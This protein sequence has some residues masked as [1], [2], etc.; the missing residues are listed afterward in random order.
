MPKKDPGPPQGEGKRTMHKDVPNQQSRGI[1]NVTA[2]L[3][4]SSTSSFVYVLSTLA[5]II[6]AWYA[7][8]GVSVAS[9]VVSNA[10]PFGSSS[11]SSSKSG[12][13]PVNVG[14]RRAAREEGVG[15]EMSVE[16]HIEELAKAF[17]MPSKD[18][19]GAIAG[20]VREHVP[21]SSLSS[22]SKKAEKTGGS[23]ILDEL[24]GE[25]GEGED[26]A[27]WTDTLGTVVG[28]DDMPV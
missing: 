20:A 22:V 4:K 18:L 27:S 11:T 8:K 21:P 12:D 19:A 26:A 2:P 23:K 9:G 1:Q 6:F 24:T 25:A 13:V 17:G 14:E 28:M 3:Y 10:S 5:V 16:R 7:Y 15:G